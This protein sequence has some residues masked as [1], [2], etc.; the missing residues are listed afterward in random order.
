MGLTDVL[1]EIVLPK[2]DRVQKTADGFTARCPA[3]EDNSPSLSLTYGTTHPVIFNCHA[4]CAPEDVL[5]ALGLEWADLTAPK[6]DRG[7]KFGKADIISTY[8][9]VDEH[10]DLLFQVCRLQPKSFRQRKPKPGGGCSRQ[11]TCW[12]RAS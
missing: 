5:K 7:Q 11:R 9:Y 8:D 3:H 2:L 10:G 6:E 12:R 4:G 1:R